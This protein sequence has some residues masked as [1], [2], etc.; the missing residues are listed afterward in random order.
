M[1]T[2]T[3][4]KQILV[5][6]DNAVTREN[7]V[8]LLQREGFQVLGVANG[9]RALDHLESGERPDVILLDM[10]LPVLDGWKFLEEL[11]NWSKPL[12]IP[13][14]VTTGTILTREWAMTHG[15]AGFIHK[16]FEFADLREEIRHCLGD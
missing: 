4:V 3:A 6:E 7:L 11:R 15:C 16:P 2:S 1:V 12:R 14:I 9:R 5:V 13:I 8:V 10:L